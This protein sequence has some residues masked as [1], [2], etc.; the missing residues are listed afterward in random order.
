M[1]IFRSGT[2]DWNSLTIPF[3][4]ALQWYDPLGDGAGNITHTTAVADL[5]HPQWV[6]A[7]ISVASRGVG[8]GGI[9]IT[10]ESSLDGVNFTSNQPD[11]GVF[12]RYFRV[13]IDADADELRNVNVQ[14]SRDTITRTYQNLD[15][16]TL[17]GDVNGRILDVEGDFST[18]FGVVINNGSG[19]DDLLITDLIDISTDT[20]TFSIRDADTYGKIA[21]DGVVNIT[22]TGFPALFYDAETGTVARRR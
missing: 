12:G 9:G 20:L 15:T 18:I 13:A 16:T 10:V 6:F 5:G 2:N 11:V 8:S 21:V 1:P 22:V 17:S 7:E 3:E 4:T 14:F 19:D